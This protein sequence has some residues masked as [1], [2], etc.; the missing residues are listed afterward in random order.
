MEN[1][2]TVNGLKY[3]L[4]QAGH[5]VKADTLTVFSAVRGIEYQRSRLGRFFG[6]LK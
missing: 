2:C 4:V 3:P 6:G 1:V 5:G